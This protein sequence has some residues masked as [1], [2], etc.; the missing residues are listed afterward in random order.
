MCA[1]DR[2]PELAGYRPS[3]AAHP[4]AQLGS[5]AALDLVTRTAAREA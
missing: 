3:V 5:K 1:P 4:L 2:H